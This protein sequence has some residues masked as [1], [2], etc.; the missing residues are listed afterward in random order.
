MG[1]TADRRSSSRGTRRPAAARGSA[2]TGRGQARRSGTRS[3]TAR[4]SWGRR[5]GIAFALL[6]VGAS[7]VFA[8]QALSP[9][10]PA[11][12][13]AGS[14]GQS[15]APT[16]SPTTLPLAPL[17]LLP[18]TTLTTEPTTSLNGRFVEQLPRDGSYRLRIYLNGELLRDRRLPRRDEFTIDDVALAEGRNS[19]TLAVAGPAGESLHSAPIEIELDS[20]AP[21]ISLLSP[22]GGQTVYAP[23]TALRG[24]SEPGATLRVTNQATSQTASLVVADDGSFEI[25]IDLLNGFNELLLDA[26]DA[27]GNEAHARLTVE[28]REGAPSVRLRLSRTSLDAAALPTTIWLEA[29]VSDASGAP[30]DGAEVVFSLSPPG[31]PTTT[32]IATTLGGVARWPSVRISDDAQQGQGLATVMVTL[33]DGETLTASEFFTIE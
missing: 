18:P 6:V 24:T 22:S 21:Q 8:S 13:P 33:L 9:T 29:E 16:R 12:G 2:R 28:R 14:G 11:D 27:A 1:R 5:L 10:G 19:F 20:T 17:L 15:S 4:V 26:R 30:I 7:V 32:Y 31:L 3:P 25:V 23:A